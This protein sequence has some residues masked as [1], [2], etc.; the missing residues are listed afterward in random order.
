VRDLARRVA[1]S[2]FERRQA[3]GFPGLKADRHD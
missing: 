1:E 2:Y 3:L